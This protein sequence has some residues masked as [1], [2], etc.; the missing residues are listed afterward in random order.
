M[1]EQTQVQEP[2]EIITAREGL[3]ATNKL[4]SEAVGITVF[5]AIVNIA[6]GALASIFPDF[7]SS[8]ADSGFGLVLFGLLYMGMAWGIQKRSRTCVVIALV[9]FVADAI[10]SMV[11]GN[12]VAGYAMKVFI[13]IGLVQ[14]LRGCFQYHSIVRKAKGELDDRPLNILQADKRPIPKKWFIILSIIAVLGFGSSIYGL[15]SQVLMTPSFDKWQ[16]YTSVSGTVT[17][18]VPGEVTEDVQSIP[19][20]AGGKYRI[21]SA[22]TLQYDT[23]LFS[24]TGLIKNQTEEQLKE[25]QSRL[26]DEIVTN[27]NGVVHKI[28]QVEF[29]GI[30]ASQSHFTLEDGNTGAVRAFCADNNI[31]LACILQKSGKNIDIIDQFME[32]IS[33]K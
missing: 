13:I 28:E 32:S 2:Q 30:T 16:S 25:L 31:Y 10:M 7:L 3:K 1:E 18:K 5:V 6:L 29:D 24:Y 8:Y 12:G 9:V 27:M 19:N 33:L 17:M 22:T 20:V 21:E 14:G 11:E 4:I 26:T 23:V 15:F